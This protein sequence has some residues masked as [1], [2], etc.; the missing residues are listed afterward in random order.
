MSTPMAAE[1]TLQTGP[2][3]A[4]GALD[5]ILGSEDPARGLDG[6]LQSGD[7]QRSLPEV[8]AIVDFHQSCL[9]HHKDLWAHTL[10]VM[11][12]TEADVDLRWAVLMHDVGKIDT[13]AL[14]SRHR[15]TFHRHEERGAAMMGQVAARM[16]MAAN[17]VARITFIIE[18]HGWVNAYSPTWSDRAVRRLIRRSGPYLEDLL[19]FS[20]SD[21]TTRQGPKRRRI[22]RTLDHLTE[23]I[24][25]L[26]TE[27]AEEIHLPR[28]LGAALAK[29]HDIPPGPELGALIAKLKTRVAAG[30]VSRDASLEELIAAAG[31]L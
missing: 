20:R 25:R 5:E 14:D 24:S 30:E 27:D 31:E 18:H 11:E 16:G 21:Y 23:R 28:G 7:L 19:S 2:S 12:R 1:N 13:R 3:E 22:A 10:E 8:H 29:A 9:V 17:R 4:L 6:L 26:Q 15:V